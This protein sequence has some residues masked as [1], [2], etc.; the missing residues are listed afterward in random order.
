LPGAK[1][2]H[3]TKPCANKRN[4]H[5][6]AK[7]E[8]IQEY[9]LRQVAIRFAL[10][11]CLVQLLLDNLGVFEA[12]WNKKPGNSGSD[13]NYKYEERDIDAFSST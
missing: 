7:P 4:K 5:Q 3:Q 10:C 12:G 6:K 1:Q 13:G 9:A 11:H 8:I 2:Y